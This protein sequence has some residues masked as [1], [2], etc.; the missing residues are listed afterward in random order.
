MAQRNIKILITFSLLLFLVFGCAHIN[1]V[2]KTYDPTDQV[3]VYYAKEDIP[4][5]YTVMGHA[6]GGGQLLVSTSKIQ[7]ELIEKA[8]STGADA[9]LITEI[10][11]EISEENDGFDAE[12][13]VKATFLKYK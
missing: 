8:K 7:N 9:I 6:V 5:E 13:Q 1:Y 3:D 12:K 10:G 11:R 2:G 4:R